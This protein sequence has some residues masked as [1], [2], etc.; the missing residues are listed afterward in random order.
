LNKNSDK[1]KN[2]LKLL[3]A[4]EMP[5]YVKNKQQ[6]LRGSTWNVT[7]NKETKR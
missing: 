1:N 7:K 3:I 4:W 5:Y 2:G 6:K